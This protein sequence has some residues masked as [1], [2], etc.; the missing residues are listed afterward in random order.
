M[1]CF[2]G[3]AKAGRRCRA[4]ENA[5]PAL[6]GQPSRQVP[7]N[8][9]VAL[10][11]CDSRPPRSRR[12]NSE[13]AE[14]SAVQLLFSCNSSRCSTCNNRKRQRRRHSSRPPH[15][16]DS[17]SRSSWML[18]STDE[19]LHAPIL[20]ERTA[21]AAAESAEPKPRVLSHPDS[22][23]GHLPGKGVRYATLC[24]YLSTQHDITRSIFRHCVN[25]K[26]PGIDRLLTEIDVGDRAC[27]CQDLLGDQLSERSHQ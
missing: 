19:T 27:V 17:I 15:K 23:H 18:L 22:I 4:N 11:A 10:A 20:L 5:H 8:G 13:I 26:S 3:A 12:K 1:P 7:P 25:A 16:P 14:A 9:S 2:S 24:R 6:G 21:L